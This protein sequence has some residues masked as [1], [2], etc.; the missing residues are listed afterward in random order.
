MN[1]LREKLADYAHEAWSGWMNYM[2]GKCKIISYPKVPNKVDI[3]TIEIPKTLFERWQYQMN[4]AYKNLPEEMKSSDRAEADKMIEIFN[5]Q[6][7]K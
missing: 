1:T 5:N 3:V 2:F 7:E 6:K 4:T